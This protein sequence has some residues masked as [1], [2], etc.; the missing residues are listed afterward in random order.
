MSSKRYFY[1]DASGLK[2][3]IA[4]HRKAEADLV[5]RMAK[6]DPNDPKYKVVYDSYQ[7]ILA[8]LRQSKAEVVSKIG[9]KNGT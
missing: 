6:L 5:E 9:K 3:D 7:W 2:A 1:S 4:R 8:E